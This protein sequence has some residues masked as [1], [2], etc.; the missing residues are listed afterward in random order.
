MNNRLENRIKQQAPDIFGSEP[1]TGHRERFAAKLQATD[2]KRQVPFRIIISYLSAAA[3]LAGVIYFA[4][5]IILPETGTEESLYEVQAYYAMLL[6]DKISEIEPLLQ[7]VDEE[8]RNTLIRDIET[9]QQ[10]AE[11]YIQDSGENNIPFIVKVYSTK[12]EAIEH[13]QDILSP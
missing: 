1:S 13:I 9:L 11:A 12:I 5:D 6:Q 8:D 3:V 2:R 10:E 7:N 4:K